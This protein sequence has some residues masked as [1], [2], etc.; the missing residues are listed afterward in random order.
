MSTDDRANAHVA[1]GQRISP[2]IVASV[3][4]H[5]ILLGIGAWVSARLVDSRFQL[6]PKP[7]Q[8]SLVR[9]GKPRDEKLLPTK[10]APEVQATAPAP[11][12]ESE[13]PAPPEP[14]LLPPPPIPPPQ[15]AEKPQ[16]NTSKGDQQALRDAF[17]RI[18]RPDVEGSPDG[19]PDGN[20]AKQ[21]GERYYGLLKSVIDRN[22]DVSATI[23]EAQRRSLTADVALWING[24][25]GILKVELANASGNSLFDSAVMLAIRKA[26]PFTPPPAHLKD[27]LER[28]GVVFKF[29][30]T[31]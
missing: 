9:L 19:D 31:K 7:I 24:T 30:A 29:R 5:L 10:A 6:E 28:E 3:I 14:S 17:A 16:E 12:K 15:G 23:P 4:G 8:A 11:A 2:Y 26:A 27:E 21:E 1:P 18:G 22:Y 13:A 20:A 25:G